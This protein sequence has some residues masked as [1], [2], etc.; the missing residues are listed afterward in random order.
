MRLYLDT[1]ILIFLLLDP[2]SLERKVL[3][4]LSDYGNTL[5]TSEVC[6]HEL[7]HL[8]QIGKAYREKRK[9][10]EYSGDWVLPSLDEAGITIEPITRKH[11]AAYASLPMQR[12]HRDPFDR[13]IIAQSIADRGTLV[14]SDL[15]MPWYRRHGLQLVMNER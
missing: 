13:L 5:H 15:K 6:A 9:D 1:N 2:H 12:D 4:M 10:E 11:L 7:I 14:T 8:A 3:S